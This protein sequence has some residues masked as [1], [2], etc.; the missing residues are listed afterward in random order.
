MNESN[1]L[2]TN[3]SKRLVV[4][5]GGWAGIAAAMEGVRKGF[6]VTLLE[7]RP[8]LGGRAHSF[9][10]KTTSTEIDNGQHLLM[11]CYT[12]TL[13]V[14]RDLGTDVLLNKQSALRVVF[15][16]ADGRRD[17]LNASALPGK[18]G[19]L[20]GIL[21]LRGISF[22]GRIS[23]V[24]FATRL[25]LNRVDVGERTCLQ[26]LTDEGQTPDAIE[27]FW[28]PVV[29]ATL[30]ASIDVA[31]SELLVQVLRLAFFSGGDNSK[32]YIPTVG[33]SSL[34]E[35]FTNWMEQRGGEVKLGTGVDQIVWEFG[36]VKGVWLRDGSFLEA[37][38]VVAAVPTIALQRLLTTK[39]TSD[40]SISRVFEFSPIISVYLWYDRTWLTDDF[41][42]MLGTN[43]QWVFNKKSRSGQLI[44]LTISAASDIV[45]RSIDEIIELC[46][47]ELRGAFPQ[48]KD[49]QRIHGAVIKEKTATPLLK[50]DERNKR[51]VEMA[52]MP[53]NIAIA[54]DWTDTHLPATIEGAARSGVAAIKRLV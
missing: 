6:R 49:V 46:D 12:E 3:E 19:V 10:D 4:V 34:I 42:A 35:P 20:I 22:R 21:R 50:P 48:M 23:I 18:L 37:D 45:S 25:L 52:E 53:I 27:R 24:K 15:V 39:S 8:Y 13:C 47:A 43:I 9:V 28:K 33:L 36:V 11:G 32:L 17:E 54:G 30:N 51:V 44:S 38:A 2:T 16:D 31:D 26:L 41:I 5:G 14:L 1:L 29:L 7:E 40:L